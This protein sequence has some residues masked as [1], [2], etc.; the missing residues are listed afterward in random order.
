MKLTAAQYR[1]LEAVRDGKATRRYSAKGNTLYAPGVGAVVLWRV[2][3]MH[4]IVEKRGE[5]VGGGLHF[6]RSMILTDAGRKALGA[7]E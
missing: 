1:A 6:R 4:L 5:N 3:N 7:H 2:E